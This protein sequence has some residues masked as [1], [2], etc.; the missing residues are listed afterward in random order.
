MIGADHIDNPVG[1]RAPQGLAVGFALVALEHGIVI[2]H[3]LP[4]LHEQGLSDAA[5]VTAAS[6]IGPMQVAGRLGMVAV[7]NRVGILAIAMLSVVCLAGAAMSLYLVAAIG[8][9]AVAFVLLQG[10]G[11]GVVS[12]VR[13]VLTAECMGREH[14]GAISGVVALMFMGMLAIAPSVASLLWRA[15]GYDLVIFFAM[16]CC[17]ASLACLSAV[18]KHRRRA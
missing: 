10:A 8:A 12:I 5:A 14:F 16:A 3:L 11:N 1:H 9:F 7:Q 13:P 6:M 18:A 2:T 4:I 15:G 17:A